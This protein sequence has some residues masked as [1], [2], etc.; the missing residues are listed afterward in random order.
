MLSD[1]RLI[2]SRKSYVDT[3]TFLNSTRRNATSTSEKESIIETLMVAKRD[4]EKISND[5][6]LTWY[7]S[8]HV[9]FETTSNHF[10]KDRGPFVLVLIDGNRML[11]GARL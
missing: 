9:V 6:K 2:F 1:G 7:I 10:H 5:Y 4:F 11:V 3:K 8:V